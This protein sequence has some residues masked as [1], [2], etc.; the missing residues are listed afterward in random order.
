MFGTAMLTSIEERRKKSRNVVLVASILLILIWVIKLSFPQ[1]TVLSVYSSH[2]SVESP[3]VPAPTASSGPYKD[4]A[5]VDGDGKW[6]SKPKDSIIL[7]SDVYN[8]TLTTK[9]AVIVE[10]RYRSN[11]IP[12]IL[13]FSNVLGPTWPII[14]YTSAESEGQFVTSAALKRYVK[15]GT[16]EVRLLPQTVMFMNSNS[17]DKFMTDDWLWK[18]LAPAEHI[19]IFQSDS[20]LCA[21]AARS[22]DDY[23]QYDLVGVPIKAGLGNGYNG[24]L[25]LR[26]RSTVMRILENWDWE[27]SVKDGHDRFEDQWYYNR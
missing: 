20:M 2:T 17:V 8:G 24:G 12:L 21:N 15:M 13:H 22:V 11:L 18:E 7:N 25:S 26:K 6:I 14:I 23:F 1:H 10:T 16:I 5:H 19:L 27:E 4:P 3:D 9:A